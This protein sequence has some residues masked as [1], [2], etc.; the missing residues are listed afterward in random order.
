MREQAW[1]LR[2]MEEDRLRNALR[3]HDLQ[4]EAAETAAV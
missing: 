4:D 2:A 3:V 1:L